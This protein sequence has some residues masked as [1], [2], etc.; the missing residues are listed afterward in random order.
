MVPFAI[1]QLQ[2]ASPQ[3]CPVGPLGVISFTERVA[4]ASATVV[5]AS[6]S[7]AKL[8]CTKE[9]KAECMVHDSHVLTVASAELWNAALVRASLKLPV[10]NL[11][12]SVP[13][14]Y[15]MADQV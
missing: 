14:L 12:P 5:T 9:A 13:S 1:E 8:D 3:Q 4:A 2:R 6:A 7:K 11:N 10:L 15:S